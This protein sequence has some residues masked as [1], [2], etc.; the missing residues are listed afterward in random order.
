MPYKQYLWI[1]SELGRIFVVD[2]NVG[3][4][5]FDL[6]FMKMQ[7]LSDVIEIDAHGPQQMIRCLLLVETRVKAKKRLRIWSASATDNS[8]VIF[9]PKV[10]IQH[11]T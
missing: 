5:I 4:S 9:N 1:G 10:P 2:E 3:Q 8:I 7:N 6:I 11:F